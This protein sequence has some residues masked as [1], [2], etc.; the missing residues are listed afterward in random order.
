MPAADNLS[1]V[2]LSKQSRVKGVWFLSKNNVYM[3]LLCPVAAWQPTCML[4]SGAPEIIIGMALMAI[5]FLNGSVFKA[6]MF[7]RR[8]SL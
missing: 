1:L 3:G 5:P 4:L 8:G 6:L 2:V 7:K